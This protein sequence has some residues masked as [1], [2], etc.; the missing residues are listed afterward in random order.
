MKWSLRQRNERR[1]GGNLQDITKV[2]KIGKSVGFTDSWLL[3]Q[4]RH[5]L[6]VCLFCMPANNSNNNVIFSLRAKTAQ[7]RFTSY[8]LN[9]LS[10]A[11]FDLGGCFQ[12]WV[13]MLH[14]L[15]NI[16]T[17]RVA[18][19]VRAQPSSSLQPDVQFQLMKL[20]RLC[21]TFEVLQLL[22]PPSSLRHDNTTV[23]PSDIMET[24]FSHSLSLALFR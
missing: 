20:T 3:Q 9:P 2:L 23:R 18:E 19:A 7:R 12:I 8:W 22:Q 11:W 14:M 5:T 1:W 10:W 15:T 21:N 16:H 17:Q 6:F 24:L 13:K 4:N